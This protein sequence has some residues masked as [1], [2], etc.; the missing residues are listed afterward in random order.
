MENDVY[1][2]KRALELSKKG[3]GMVSPNPMVGAV[4]VNNGSIIGEGYHKYFGGNHAEINAMNNAREDLSGSTLYINLEPCC[5]YGKTPPCV[6]EIIKAGIKR[7]VISNRDPNPLVNGKSISYL[8][9]KS[10]EV[11]QGVLKED[12]LWMNRFYFKY[13]TKKLPYVIIKIAQTI[14]AKIK[15]LNQNERWITSKESRTEVHRMRQEVDAILIGK[16]TAIKDNPG[17][18]VRHV[19]GKDPRRVVLD[20]FLET[21]PDLKIYKDNNV[22]LFT[23]QDTD[24]DKIRRFKDMGITVL[25]AGHEHAERLLIQDVLKKLG[26]REI[27]SVMVE[28]GAKIFSSFIKEEVFDE[29]VLFMAPKF[30]PIG[31]DVF[32]GTI[33]KQVDHLPEIIF[34]DIKKI[35]TD[36]MI[37]C[38]LSD[39][40]TKG[41][42]VCL[43]E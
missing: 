17:L 30:Y 31:L 21:T 40:N 28:G 15:N 10:I 24:S 23:R 1:Y 39:K 6:N 33:L 19:R 32:D 4:I 36:I 29:I 43:Q 7:V 5:H 25:R 27:S 34:R 37:R 41:T 13:M 20:P 12:G 26:E 35:G 11:K 18:T 3:M 38:L 42:N 8:K 16:E 9:D 22:I 2:M 14:N